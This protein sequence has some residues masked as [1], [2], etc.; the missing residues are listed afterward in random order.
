MFYHLT[1]LILGW[2]V[3][4]NLQDIRQSLFRL[5]SVILVFFALLTT[6]AWLYLFPNEFRRY[7]EELFV[8]LFLMNTNSGGQETRRMLFHF[9][10]VALG[11]Q[12]S[13]VW[14][15]LFYFLKEKRKFFMIVIALLIF[16]SVVME[17]EGIHF[18]FIRFS[19]SFLLGGHL[20]FVIDRNFSLSPR[21]RNF[22]F[23]SF[24]W[25][26]PFWVYSRLIQVN[27]DLKSVLSILATFFVIVF[28]TWLI[29]FKVVLRHHFRIPIYLM[30]TVLLVSQNGSTFALMGLNDFRLYENVHGEKI[31]DEMIDNFDEYLKTGEGEQKIVFLGDSN[32][33][34]FTTHLMEI[35]VGSNYQFHFVYQPFDSRLASQLAFDPTTKKVVLMYTWMKGTAGIQKLVRELDQ[36]GKEVIVIGDLPSGSELERFAIVGRSFWNPIPTLNHQY[37]DVDK[38][39]REHRSVRDELV[40]IV[41]ESKGRFIDPI[42]YLCISE[43]CPLLNENLEPIFLNS[44]YIRPHILGHRARFLDQIVITEAP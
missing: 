18:Q 38:F 23:I 13:V 26:W 19:W 8:S 9:W 36:K 22:I 43:K 15:C 3:F 29:S 31:N 2:T 6:F 21:I 5:Y 12:F 37:F 40:S 44:T 7:C 42:P 30:L 28:L 17:L 11:F 10:V 34:M 35:N 25:S 33:Q 4:Q 14:G 41:N 32:L 1:F 27:Q 24:L 20:A 39:Q 16:A